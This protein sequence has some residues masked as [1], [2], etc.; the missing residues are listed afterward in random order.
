MITEAAILYAS[1]AYSEGDTGVGMQFAGK[2]EYV[3]SAFERIAP[4]YDGMNLFMSW[5]LIKRW[6]RFVISEAMLPKAAKILDVCTGTGE[7]AILLAE[8]AGPD[9]EVIGLDMVEAMLEVAR[10]KVR[11]RKRSCTTKAGISFMTG[12]AL[13]LPFLPESFNCVTMGFA[14]RNVTNIY[15]A[16]SEMYRVCKKDGLVI[17]LEISEPANVL[18]R[19]GFCLYFYHVIPLFGRLVD[20]DSGRSGRMPAYT[21]LRESMKGFPQG[22]EMTR[23]FSDAGLADVCYY[24]LHGGIVTVY[25]GTKL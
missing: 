12:D 2:R 3:Q 8:K 9:S 22:V 6:Q 24:P 16:V 20:H 4:Y 17:C 14:L 5:G 10:K 23:I 15:R 18:W 21:W 7:L 11:K 13:R 25:R 1:K 19:A